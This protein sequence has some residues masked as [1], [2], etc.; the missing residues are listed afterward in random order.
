MGVLSVN[1]DGLHWRVCRYKLSL[2]KLY[3]QQRSHFF[4]EIKAYLCCQILKLKM[5]YW[6]NKQEKYLVQEQLVEESVIKLS[7]A[8]GPVIWFDLSLPWSPWN[9]IVCPRTKREKLLK[10][11]TYLTSSS[12]SAYKQKVT[13]YFL[14]LVPACQVSQTQEVS[15]KAKSLPGNILGWLILITQK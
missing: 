9:I 5:S 12:W 7:Q 4:S 6:L 2:K 10:P 14:S 3:A 11:F 8:S 15:A 13:H 1:K